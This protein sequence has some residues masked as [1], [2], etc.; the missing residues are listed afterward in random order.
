MTVL[1]TKDDQLDNLDT[2]Y[3][4]DVLAS[5]SDSFAWDDYVPPGELELV[6]NDGETVQG[7]LILISEWKAKLPPLLSA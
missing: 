3:K 4:R 2:A 6:K 5:L 7:T 1:E